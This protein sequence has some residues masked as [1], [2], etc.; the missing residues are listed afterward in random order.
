MP[1]KM[2]QQRSLIDRGWQQMTAILDREM[3]LQRKRR[4]GAIWFFVI[5]GVLVSGAIAFGYFHNTQSVSESPAHSSPVS[6]PMQQ[7][8]ASAM[9]G[10]ANEMS[11]SSETVPQSESAAAHTEIATE[12]VVP[13]KVSPI[14]RSGAGLT[15]MRHTLPNAQA[16]HNPLPEQY[17]AQVS[18]TTENRVDEL[19]AATGQAESNEEMNATARQ[20]IALREPIAVS[21]LGR[22]ALTV[23]GEKVPCR[24]TIIQPVLKKN[25]HLEGLVAVHLNGEGGPFYGIEAG[26]L[27]AVDVQRH[28]RMFAGVTGVYY[29]TS[30]L[31]HIGQGQSTD[32]AKAFTDPTTGN[33]VPGYPFD[34]SSIADN[35]LPYPS[36]ARLTEAFYYLNF[37]V[38]IEYRVSPRI[39]VAAG[40][41]ALVLLSA[42]ARYRL[43]NQTSYVGVADNRITGNR[44]Y[45]YHYDILRKFDVAPTVGVSWQAG[46]HTWIDFGYSFGLVPYINRSGIP[47]RND[48]HRAANVGLRFDII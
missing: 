38:R 29:N 8:S 41:K 27:S 13:G 9:A 14:S 37:P 16:V 12:A 10:N 30:G 5:L 20:S 7:R 42:P 17:E 3:P 32:L 45:L 48:F 33:Y 24:T 31:T 47:G 39:S 43:E 44:N 40:V 46:M 28:I 18:E 4:P 6:E 23:M 1:D 19:A 26:V 36:T 22:N 15:T 35:T 2:Q 21:R 11:T 34:L 25:L